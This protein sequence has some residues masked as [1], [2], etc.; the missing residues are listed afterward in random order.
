MGLTSHLLVLFNWLDGVNL[1][2]AFRSLPLLAKGVPPMVLFFLLAYFTIWKELTLCIIT[3]AY[4]VT[5]LTEQPM[6]CLKKKKINFN[7]FLLLLR[8]A[9]QSGGRAS[10]WPV[11]GCGLGP[12]APV[13]VI[14]PDHPFAMSLE[15]IHIRHRCNQPHVWQLRQDQATPVIRAS[16]RPCFKEG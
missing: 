13:Q 5:Y 7:F 2:G 10:D 15:G 6:V 12:G 9:P 4:H 8:Q 1:F 14:M 16:K 3:S 11:P